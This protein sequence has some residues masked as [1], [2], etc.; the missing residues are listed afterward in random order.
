MSGGHRLG[1]CSCTVI[2]KGVVRRRC[3]MRKT[4]SKY[5]FTVN[6]DLNALKHKQMKGIEI[7]TGWNFL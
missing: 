5:V 7:A 4:P 1:L 6:L 2:G 3:C